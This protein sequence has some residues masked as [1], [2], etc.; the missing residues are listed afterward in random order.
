MRADEP[1]DDELMRL[2]VTEPTV[3]TAEVRRQLGLTRDLGAEYRAS[4]AEWQDASRTRTP[5]ESE[6][7]HAAAG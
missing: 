5:T 1:T 7:I 2:L 3:S 4:G 6:P